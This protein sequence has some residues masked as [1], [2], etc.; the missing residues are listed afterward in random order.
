M[1]LPLEEWEVEHI[2]HFT[3]HKW[4]VRATELSQLRRRR[5]RE[6]YA[7]EG[8]IEEISERTCYDERKTDKYAHR[9]FAT[10]ER[11]DIVA[12]TTNHGNA[13]YRECEFSPIEAVGGYLHAEC[14]AVVLD[15]EE[16]KPRENLYLLTIEHIC[17][18]PNFEYLISYEQHDDYRC[19]DY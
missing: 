15:K 3:H 11:M 12:Q 6:Y 16:F 4:C 18:N 5:F 10:N 14:C 7:V 1:I 19:Y 2:H 17:L 9:Y 13:E 8:A